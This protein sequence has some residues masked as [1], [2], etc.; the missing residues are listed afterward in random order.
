MNKPPAD[1]RRQNGKRSLSLDGM[2]LNTRFGWFNK[3]R[4]LPHRNDHP[5]HR[6]VA[7]LGNTVF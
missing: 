3:F 2:P 1:T 7:R 6:V 5:T 4:V